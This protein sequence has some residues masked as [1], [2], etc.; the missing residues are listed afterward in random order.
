MTTA[1]QCP[2]CGCAAPERV[3]VYYIHDPVDF[4]RIEAKVHIYTCTVCGMSFTEEAKDAPAKV[5][6]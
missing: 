3:G 6:D 1:P 4:T 2:N 5:A